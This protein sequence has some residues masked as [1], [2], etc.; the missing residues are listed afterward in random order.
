M[1]R[2]VLILCKLCYKR[3]LAGPHV[4]AGV[5][6]GQQLNRSLPRCGMERRVI[7]DTRQTNA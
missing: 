2:L 6:S 3:A 5:P 1:T 4:G 7:R